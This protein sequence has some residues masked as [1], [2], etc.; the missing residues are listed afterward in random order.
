MEKLNTIMQLKLR[1]VIYLLAILLGFLASFYPFDV[2]FSES[3]PINVQL[4][5]SLSGLHIIQDNTIVASHYVG[6]KNDRFEAI[7]TGY[8]SNVWETDDTPY[9]TASGKTVA[10]G[11]VANNKLPFGTKIKIPALFGN[12][13]FTVEDRMSPSKRGNQVDIWFP[14]TSEASIFG[15][16]KAYVEILTS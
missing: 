16:H 15:V 7:L 10:W 6:L 14:S 3:S 12:T 9:T 13:V 8:A 2:L 1:A 5:S 11:I 4:E